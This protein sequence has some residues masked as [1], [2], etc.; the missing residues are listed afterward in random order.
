MAAP[1]L[2]WQHHPFIW[3]LDGSIVLVG[4]VA[5]GPSGQ[6]MARARLAR[7]MLGAV[8]LGAVPV[9]HCADAPPKRAPAAA[10][11]DDGGKRA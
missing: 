6:S 2:I 3:Q 11:V 7:A 5:C 10:A 4:V 9:A 8:G 1:N